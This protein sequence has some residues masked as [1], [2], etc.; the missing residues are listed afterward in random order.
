MFKELTGVQSSAISFDLTELEKR[1]KMF[2]DMELEAADIIV[3]WW[4][5]NSSSKCKY[6]LFWEE[7]PRFIQEVI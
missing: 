6:D 1:V 4:H 5:L 2:I 7:C 3:D